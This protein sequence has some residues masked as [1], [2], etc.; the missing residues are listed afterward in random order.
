[1]GLRLMMITLARPSELRKGLW[2]GVGSG[3]VG[4]GLKP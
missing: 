3:A 2:S 1:M 4:A